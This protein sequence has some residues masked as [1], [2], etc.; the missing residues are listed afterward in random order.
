RKSRTLSLDRAHSQTQ[1]PWPL[2]SAY[3]VLE[4]VDQGVVTKVS[5]EKALIAWEQRDEKR[6][7]KS[8]VKVIA[9]RDI[10]TPKY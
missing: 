5:F 7:S 10:K 3:I 1:N 6:P 2:P 8:V 9:A 4:A